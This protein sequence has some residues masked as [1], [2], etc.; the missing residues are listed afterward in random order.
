MQLIFLDELGVQW[1]RFS[2]SDRGIRFVIY[3]VADLERILRLMEK[4]KDAG[5]QVALKE[6]RLVEFPMQGGGELDTARCV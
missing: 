4:W 3:I 2:A 1:F 5:V 6:A